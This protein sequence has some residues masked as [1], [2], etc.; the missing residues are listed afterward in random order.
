[1]REGDTERGKDKK[2]G[3]QRRGEGSE[4]GGMAPTWHTARRL[5]GSQTE[6][7][8]HHYTKE[9][10]KLLSRFPGAPN[11]AAPYSHSRLFVLSARFLIARSA[12][13]GK[14]RRQIECDVRGVDSSSCVKEEKT[15]G[16]AAGGA[17]RGSSLVAFSGQA[18]L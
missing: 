12:R 5:L 4:T 15:A 18:S 17:K 8:T 1:M 16:S 11:E 13:S 2:R 9:R 6:G 14:R 7:L 3:K 10:G